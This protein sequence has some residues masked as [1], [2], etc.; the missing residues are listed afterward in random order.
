M[1]AADTDGLANQQGCTLLCG[2]I[3][4][5]RSQREHWFAWVFD[6][7]SDRIRDIPLRECF[8]IGKFHD[9]SLRPAQK[10]PLGQVLASCDI[11]NLRTLPQNPT[12]STAR[13]PSLI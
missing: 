8:I 1:S 5:W 11:P 7:R 3:K 6:T 2:I 12:A 9:L 10:S 4:A 13:F